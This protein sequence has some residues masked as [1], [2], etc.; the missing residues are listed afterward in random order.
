MKEEQRMEEN[1]SYIDIYRLFAQIMKL[2]FSE[3]FSHFHE[4]KIHPAQA[5]LLYILYRNPGITQSALAKMLYIAPS[6]VAISLNR[7]E[8][9]GYVYREK[10]EDK[11][12]SLV[13]LTDQGTQA[14]DAVDALFHQLNE[15][16]TAML[17]PDEIE[18][19]SALL[20][21]IRDGFAFDR[22]SACKTASAEQIPSLQDKIT[23]K[24]TRNVET[25]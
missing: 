16:F 24:G 8:E 1:E 11:R 19:L 25:T 10:G 5:E 18:I 17:T 9:A 3:A 21:K 4:L 7:L 2:S 22:M 12:K 6:T 14:V 20:Y 15:Q 23:Q 13:F